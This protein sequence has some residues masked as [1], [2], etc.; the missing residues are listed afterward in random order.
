M[1]VGACRAALFAVVDKPEGGVFIDPSWSAV[2]CSNDDE[3]GD[4]YA[5]QSTD[6]TLDCEG[7][8]SVAAKPFIATVIVVVEHCSSYR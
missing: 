2:R 1:Y 8:Y 7:V 5:R 3:D 4:F 6:V